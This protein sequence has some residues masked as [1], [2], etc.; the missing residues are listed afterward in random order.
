[1]R[2]G[3]TVPALAVS[4]L[5]VVSCGPKAGPGTAAAPPAAAQTRP[6]TPAPTPAPTPQPG[7]RGKHHEV[8]TGNFDLVD[9]IAW[10]AKDG[11]GTVVYAT[12]KPIA[13]AALAGS[14]CPMTEARALT[15]IR[16]AGWVEITLDAKGKS[17]Y[18]SAGTAFGGT[19]REEDVADGHYWKSSLA[20]D[21]GRAS[22]QVAHLDKGGFEFTLEV[23]A[24]RI[25]EISE[26]DKVG[27]KRSDPEGITPTEG[28]VVAAYKK[29][30]AAAL[31]KDLKAVLAAQGFSQKQIDAIRALPGIDADL[32]G[33]ADRFLKPGT[34][35]EFQGYPGYGAITGE[36]VNS[37]KQKFINFYWFSPCEGR[38]VLT[39]IYENE[40]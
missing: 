2:L 1:M 9:G 24:P 17:K 20:L 36:G 39:N 37:K 38:L 15:S 33:Y 4:L 8:N 18:Y 35:G 32:S 22:G 16:N 21:S 5:L 3:W 10:T 34:T 25:T 13:S 31:K 26:T 14:P 7:L 12:S 30:R 11:A 40:Q 19:G 29:I 28:Q 27:G 6:P 23:L